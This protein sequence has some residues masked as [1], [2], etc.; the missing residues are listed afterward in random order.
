[1]SLLEVTDLTV[2]FGRSRA[3]AVDGISFALGAT[4]RLGIIGQSGSGKSVTALAVMGLLPEHAEVTGSIRF[5]GVE[6]VGM[7]ERDRRALRGDRMSMVFQEP[8]TALDPTM[9]VGRQLG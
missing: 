7:P 9:R 8:M 6:L 5:D 2:R 3:V 1:M 4:D